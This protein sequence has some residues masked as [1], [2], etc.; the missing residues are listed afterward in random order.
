MQ[1]NQIGLLSHPIYQVKFK[2]DLKT[3]VRSE[4]IQFLEENTGSMP[5]DMSLSNIF[6]L[7]SQ[8]KETKAK[9]K[10]LHQTKNLF[11]AK[12]IIDE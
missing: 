9:I 3:N 6:L 2:M 8:A 4:T 7:C 10:G 5:F 1:K 12:E 11:I